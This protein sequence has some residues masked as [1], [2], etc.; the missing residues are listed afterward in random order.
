MNSFLREHFLRRKDRGFGIQ[1]VENSLD[2]DDVGTAIDQTTHL[3]GIG[4]PQIIEADGTI[5][6]IVDV[7]RDRGCAVG[8][9]ECASHE[10]PPAVL[11]LGPPRSTPRQP[12]AIAIEVVDHVLHA[13]IGL[14]DP[15]RGEGVGLQNVG[16]GDCVMIMY[17]FNRLRLR[18]RQKVVVALLMAIAGA[19][20]LA[21]EVILDETQLLDLRPHCAV[22]DED[23]LGGRLCELAEDFRAIRLGR[24]VSKEVVGGGHGRSPVLKTTND[25]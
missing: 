18:E 16:T 13:V 4:K 11:C 14:G 15:G 25:Y 23:T 12:R 9:P 22:H 24:N 2:Q 7:R 19:E 10:A 17:L 1:C 6:G 5:T 21:P 3:L 8:R 20:T